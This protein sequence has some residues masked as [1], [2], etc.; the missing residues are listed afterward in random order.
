[1]WKETKKELVKDIMELVEWCYNNNLKDEVLKMLADHKQNKYI[2]DE[3]FARSLGYK[4]KE[5]LDK[6]REDILE[7]VVYA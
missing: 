1:M 5:A 2:S 6:M 3:L 4:T 7:K